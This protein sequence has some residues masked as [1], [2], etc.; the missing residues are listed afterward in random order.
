MLTFDNVLTGKVRKRV[1]IKQ[2]KTRAEKQQA[3]FEEQAI[4]ETADQIIAILW[5]HKKI[6]KNTREAAAALLKDLE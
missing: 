2:I 4:E 3:D 5:E 6:T 1:R